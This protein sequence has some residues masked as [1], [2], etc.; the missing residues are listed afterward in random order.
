M[1]CSLSLLAKEN[2]RLWHDGNNHVKAAEAYSDMETANKM[3]VSVNGSSTQQSEGYVVFIRTDEKNRMHNTTLNEVAHRSKAKR[4]KKS[5]RDDMMPG[6]ILALGAAMA[7]VLS[8]VGALV[9]IRGPQAESRKRMLE[10]IGEY[11]R[12]L[13]DDEFVDGLDDSTSSSR[14]SL[15]REDDS[16]G[17]PEEAV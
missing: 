10:E 17:A 11:H 14:A 13:S 7:C 3:G 8:A 2:D 1:S 12:T 15:S 5:N 6:A 4:S 9:M 16:E